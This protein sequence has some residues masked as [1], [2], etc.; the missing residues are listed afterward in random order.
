MYQECCGA[1]T[2]CQWRGEY[3]TSQSLVLYL[4]LDHTQKCNNP[5]STFLL[6]GFIQLRL[7]H[8]LTIS[9]FCAMTSVYSWGMCSGT[10]GL[11][12]LNHGRYFMSTCA[13]KVMNSS[14][15]ATQSSTLGR[16]VAR[17][18]VATDAVVGLSGKCNPCTRSFT[19]YMLNQWWSWSRLDTVWWLDFWWISQLSPTIRNVG[20][21]MQE[22]GVIVATTFH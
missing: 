17:G 9:D 19:A 18:S 22:E 5:F 7:L 1:L 16:K 20:R 12:H 3:S 11:K 13:T 6:F 15:R 2:R 21:S 14:R 4:P 8:P 10:T